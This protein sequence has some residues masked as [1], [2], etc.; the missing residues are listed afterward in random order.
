MDDKLLLSML[1]YIY[2]QTDFTLAGQ[3]IIDTLAEITNSERGNLFTVAPNMTLSHNPRISSLTNE[4]FTPQM[5]MNT[6]II[7]RRKIV[8][9]DEII[10]DYLEMH[11][12]QSLFCAPLIHNDDVLGAVWLENG[13]YGLSNLDVLLNHAS[14]MLVRLS[15]YKKLERSL[16]DANETIAEQKKQLQEAQ[17]NIHRILEN[18]SQTKLNT[19]LSKR[20]I[21]ILQMLADGQN[22]NQIAPKLGIRPPTVSNQISRLSEKMGAKTRHQMMAMAG[23]FKIIKV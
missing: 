4:H 1:Q 8:N 5:V 15:S 18:D 21:S 2:L 6:A 11:N 3:R 9:A 14:V 16:Y 10:D 19:R 23:F 13:D 17:L 12:P 22:L 20:E 7:E